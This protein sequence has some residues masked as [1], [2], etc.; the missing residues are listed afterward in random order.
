MTN[1]IKLMIVDDHNAVRQALSA[2]LK[3]Y[4]F[5]TIYEA[6]NG[7][8]AV[9][10]LHE[11]KPD[12][13]LLDLN[14]PVMNGFEALA[15]IKKDYPSIKVII[16]SGHS[17]KSYVTQT[18]QS[19]ADAFLPKQCS[20]EILMHVIEDVYNNKPF[21]YEEAIGSALPTYPGKQELELVKEQ[22]S[23]TREEVEV[24]LAICEGK[25]RKVIAEELDMSMRTVI[26]YTENIYKKTLLSNKVALLKYAVRNGYIEFSE[27]V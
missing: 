9:E 27:N 23:L 19:G 3:D 13:I 20:I 22:R 16:L 18:L 17:D 7:K 24:L 8:D 14:M 11:L 6:S 2:I 15:I 5:S 1:A 26:S 25:S 10:S 21:V 4:E 12:V